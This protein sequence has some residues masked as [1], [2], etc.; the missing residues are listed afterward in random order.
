M[1]LGVAFSK[2]LVVIE[3]LVH[4]I[5][6]SIT[7]KVNFSFFTP[8]VNRLEP[9]RWAVR[10]RFHLQRYEKSTSRIYGFPRRIVDEVNL[11]CRD[12]DQSK[13]GHGEGPATD[14]GRTDLKS[15]LI[16]FFR[17]ELTSHW[18]WFWIMKRPDS[19]SILNDFNDRLT[20]PT[21]SW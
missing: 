14:E 18:R 8:N 10:I 16:V 4:L 7:L 9:D 6:I 13:W 5:S 11:L 3:T 19:C 21:S 1:P 2:F 17:V 15:Y 12:T 20:D